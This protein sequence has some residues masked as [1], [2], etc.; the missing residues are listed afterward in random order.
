MYK[1]GR[2]SNV[3][4]Q[5][6]S[7]CRALPFSHVMLQRE[8]FFSLTF[9]IHVRSRLLATSS[10]RCRCDCLLFAYFDDQNVI[11]VYLRVKRR[12]SNSELWF[13]FWFIWICDIVP[14][15]CLEVPALISDL[16]MPHVKKGPWPQKL[17][18]YKRRTS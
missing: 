13:I 5:H 9:P 6:L 17:L 1:W 8:P 15:F 2:L 18:L 11:R 10:S 14:L 7:S 16:G 3:G 12:R 4:H